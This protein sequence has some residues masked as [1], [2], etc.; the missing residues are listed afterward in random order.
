MRYVFAYDLV[1]GTS[2]GFASAP[3]FQLLVMM[4]VEV[5]SGVR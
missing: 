1:G 4:P 3:L 2:R 5:T